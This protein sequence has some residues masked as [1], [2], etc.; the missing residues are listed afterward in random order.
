MSI[1]GFDL[2]FQNINESA[3]NDQVHSCAGFLKNKPQINADE[4][5]LIKSDKKACFLNRN[6]IKTIYYR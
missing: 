1:S 3:N 2:S 4:R 5:R 6:L